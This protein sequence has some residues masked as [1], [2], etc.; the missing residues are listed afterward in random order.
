MADDV[1]RVPVAK[2]AVKT[3]GFP[4]HREVEYRRAL[5][6]RVR[7]ISKLTE[8]AIA[9][10]LEMLGPDIDERAR[11]DA[12]EGQTISDLIRVVQFIQLSAAVIEPVPL[13]PLIAQAAAVD[14]FSTLY[15]D[16]EVKTVIGIAIPSPEDAA[17][18]YLQFAEE[19]REQIKNIDDKYFEGV[20]DLV[21]EAVSE[22]KS[23]RDLAAALQQQ[24][25]I[26]KSHAQFVAR[27]SIGTLNG[28]IT[29]KRQTDL[30]ITQYKWRT[31]QD[32]RVRPEHV[33]RE[34]VTFDWSDPP[35]GGPPGFDFNCRCTAEPVLPER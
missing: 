14:R 24:A 4:D 25:A 1:D 26:S 10:A 35:E 13:D 34:G 5:T 32:V 21:R 20:N 33:E 12:S 7:M 29:E 30:G 23:T 3:P 18:L 31:S 17:A 11:Q 22:G 9:A 28:L 19:Q 8:K 6:R 15:L 16:K 2:L 27:N